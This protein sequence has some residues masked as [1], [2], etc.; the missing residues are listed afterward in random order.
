[1]HRKNHIFSTTIYT[2]NIKNYLCFH[3]VEFKSFPNSRTMN[4]QFAHVQYI[5]FNRRWWISFSQILILRLNTKMSYTYLWLLSQT[6][7]VTF[8]I[9]TLSINAFS[10]YCL[11]SGEIFGMLS[12]F[13]NFPFKFPWRIVF[14]SEIVKELDF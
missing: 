12:I 11:F 9:R 14:F 8:V 7:G 1:M 4:A 2:G 6:G 3:P 10:I 13:R 5:H